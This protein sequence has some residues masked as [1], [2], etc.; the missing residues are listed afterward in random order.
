MRIHD[1]DNEDDVQRF[2]RA[3]KNMKVV[4]LAGRF[5]A[6]WCKVDATRSEYGFDHGFE[7]AIAMQS[8]L[9]SK[10]KSK[11]NLVVHKY[12]NGNIEQVYEGNSANRRKI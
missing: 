1:M 11:Y 8:G 3:K 9:D 10:Y 12:K 6:S 4:I 7:D 5:F 2:D